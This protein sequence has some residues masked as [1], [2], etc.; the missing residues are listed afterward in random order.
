MIGSL[1]GI[2]LQIIVTVAAPETLTVRQPATITVRATVRG[3]VAPELQMPRFGPLFGSRIEQSRQV[4]SGGTMSRSLAVM[5]HKYLVVAQRPGQ[6]IIPPVEASLGPMTGR[7]AATRL[8]IVSAPAIPVPAVVSRSRLDPKSGVNFHALVAPDTVYV[9][10]QATYQVGV[11]LNDDVRYRLRRNPE[12]IPPELRSMLAYDL[13]APRSFVS[14]RVIDGRRYEVHVFQRALFPLTA[15]QYEIPPARLNYSLPLSA[16]FFSREE[17][18]QLRSETVPLV[19]VDPPQAGRPPDYNGAVGRLVLEAH[20]D[21]GAAK[22]GDPLVLTVRVTGD[23]NVSFF[24]RPDVHVPWGQLVP[25][26]E[27]VQLDSSAIVIRGAKEFDWVITPAKSG[28]QE[29]PPVRYPF[30]NPYTERYELAVTSPQRVSVAPGTLIAVDA[31]AADSAR[32]AFPVRRVMQARQRA[33]W[34]RERVFWLAMLAAPLPAGLALLVR[35]PRIRRVPTASERLRKLAKV[36]ETPSPGDAAALRRTYA[37]ALAERI[38]V[39]ATELADRRALVRALRRSGV[40]AEVARAADQLLGELDTAVY[41]GNSLTLNDGAARAMDVLQ[42]VDTEARPRII[43]VSTRSFAPVALLGLS[44]AAT[45]SEPTA[46][47]SFDRGVR[48]Y[49][50]HRYARAERFFGEATRD[51][52]TS[53]D[54]WAN[55]GT[56]AW[57]ARDTAAAAIGWQRALRLDPTATDVRSRLDLTPGFGGSELAT[58]PPITEASV[59]MVGGLAWLIGWLCAAIGIWRRKAAWRYAAYVLGIGA[60]AAAIAGVRAREAFDARRLAIVTEP[61]RLRA[62]PVLGGEPGAPALSGEVA[63]AVREEGVWSLVKMGDDREGWL[64]TDKLEPI[65]RPWSRRR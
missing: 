40:T 20:V 22:V 38:G 54:A 25:A 4:G 48:E 5:E 19:V 28:E 3:P 51:D 14:K 8:T 52:P 16:S 12:F 42:K 58:V 32:P 23:G 10:E 45:Q 41:S 13:S 29:V 37:A 36:R 62:M 6:V 15:G 1:A 2:A 9:G 17:S 18:H 39:R 50:A 53:A 64:E 26:E 35:R 43:R 47:E 21:S 55:F 49:E 65:A 34:S 24:P 7:S 63:R 30:F 27:R 59:A 61:A 31:A 46:R 56:A 33:P 60:L 44:L 57:A 11:F